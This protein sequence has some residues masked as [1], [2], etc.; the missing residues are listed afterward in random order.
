[1]LIAY[2]FGGLTA[3]LLAPFF[4][5]AY[6]ISG[7]AYSADMAYGIATVSLLFFMSR[8]EHFGLSDIFSLRKDADGLRKLRFSSGD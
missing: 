1:L 8:N 3:L 6:G 7:A 2:G 5:A 4:I